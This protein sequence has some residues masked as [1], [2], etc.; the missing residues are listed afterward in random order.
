MIII[1]IIIIISTSQRKLQL[2][3]VFLDLYVTCFVILSYLSF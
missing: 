3:F 2:S 1:I